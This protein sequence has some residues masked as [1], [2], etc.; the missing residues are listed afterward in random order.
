MLGYNLQFPLSLVLNKKSM[1]QYQ[2]LFR[3][4]FLCKYVEK[5]LC[6]VW[7]GQHF[8]RHN[9]KPNQNNKENDKLNFE[10]NINSTPKNIRRMLSTPNFST[11]KETKSTKLELPDSPKLTLMKSLDKR[12]SVLRSKM[13]ITI[14][15]FM[16]YAFLEVIEP[17]WLKMENEIKS[18]SLI[19]DLLKIH[20]GFLNSCLKECM[21][22]SP[23]LVKVILFY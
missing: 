20:N 19:Q 11:R 17:N 8:S 15:Q 12:M 18:C 4:L 2:I 1:T 16:Y 10:N 14:Q 23:K 3:Y 9:K 21:L 7:I 5:L 13:L 22:T 6:H